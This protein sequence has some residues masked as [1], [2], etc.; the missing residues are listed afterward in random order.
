M[1]NTFHFQNAAQP[2]YA[3]YSDQVAAAL[4]LFYTAGTTQSVGAFMAGWVS[5]SVEIRNYNPADAKPRVP[6]IYGI[7]L[8]A[9]RTASTS[10]HI[11]ADVAMCVSF[12][13]APPITRRKRG[14]IYLGG[15]TDEWLLTATTGSL[16]VWETTAGKVVQAVN[17]A[18]L[19]LSTPGLG[20]SVYSRV[21][22]GYQ[23][24]VGGHVDS[25]PDTQRRRG[26]TTSTRVTWGS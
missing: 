10:W 15:V 14:R 17:A 19:A 21:N 22:D 20:W 12:H 3:A 6:T 11:P 1:V 4:T 2:S 23:F 9:C 16:P 8:P 25:E 24:V 13:A 7:T 26:A 5:R 18:C